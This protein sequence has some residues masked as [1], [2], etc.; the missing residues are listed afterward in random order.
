MANKHNKTFTI[1]VEVGNLE[2]Y[3]SQLNYCI[4]NKL[5]VVTNSNIK[6][7]LKGSLLLNSVLELF[8][9]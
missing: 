7:T 5:L 3:K 6:T 4:A 8:L 2:K 9:D 1:N